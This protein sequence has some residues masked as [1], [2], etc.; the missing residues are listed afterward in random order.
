[1]VAWGFSVDELATLSGTRCGRSI[2][3]SE[4]RAA[5]VCNGALT[6]EISSATW[7]VIS[8][9]EQSKQSKCVYAER[10]DA[11]A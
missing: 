2:I 4:S 1:M 9:S 10:P 6:A 8:S 7:S 5:A 11:T 3:R